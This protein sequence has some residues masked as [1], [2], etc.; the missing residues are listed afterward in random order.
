VLAPLY[1]DTARLGQMS[2]RACRASIDFARFASE[3]GCSLYLSQLLH[4]GF[5]SWPEPLQDQYPGLADWRGLQA[6]G[7][8]FKAIAQADRGT[9][10]VVAARSAELMRFAAK[11]LIGPCRNVLVTDLS[12]PAYDTV[13][14]S[15]RRGAACRCTRVEIRQAILRERLGPQEIVERVTEAFI[16]SR[17]DG[18]FLPLVDNLGVHLPIRSIVGRIRDAAELRFTV[19]DGAQAIGHVPLELSAGYC[20]LLLAGCHKWL[21]AS[22]P[23]GLAFFGSPSSIGYIRDSLQRWLAAGDM[24]DPL[25]RFS[26]E[27]FTG[28][29]TAFGETVN[30]APLL[31]ASGAAIDALQGSAWLSS[32]ESRSEVIDLAQAAGW[33]SVSPQDG[34]TSRVLLFEPKVRK[35]SAHL[36]EL[37]RSAFL[38]AGVAL[39]AYE[40]GLIRISLPWSQLASADLD[41]LQEGFWRAETACRD[42]TAFPTSPSTDCYD[43]R[44]QT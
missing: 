3:H 24:D 28:Q 20:D 29:W 13:L 19:V 35:R 34:F 21:Q 4:E 7:D 23:L 15:V 38:S 31:T 32:Q 8:K 11:L 9:E 40:S 1:L 17:C 12:W 18:L 27:V 39:S 14:A 16:H 37:I 6:L 10:V 44:S 25:L 22:S 36:P 2:P 41:S 30:I 5:R 43:G 42:S 33:N 26:Q